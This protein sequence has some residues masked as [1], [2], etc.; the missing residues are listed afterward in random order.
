MTLDEV[1]INDHAHWIKL[2]ESGSVQAAQILMSDAAICIQHGVPL[3]DLLGGYIG[4][5]LFTSADTPEN[6][7]QAF[8][9]NKGAGTNRYLELM[10]KHLICMEVQFARLTGERYVSS[11]RGEGAYSI[12]AK[13]YGYNCE[14]SVKKLFEQNHSRWKV[15]DMTKDELLEI[16]PGYRD[17][18]KRG[19]F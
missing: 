4:K 17:L 9:L 14:E 11:S 7:L 12:V 15:K 1:S 10:R 18:H 13:A 2:A 19:D 6:I 5:A 3:P 8:N 16:L